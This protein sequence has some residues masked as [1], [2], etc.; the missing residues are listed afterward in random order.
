MTQEKIFAELDHLIGNDMMVLNFGLKDITEF[1]EANNIDLNMKVREPLPGE[2]PESIEDIG[3][4]LIR[5]A[6][7]IKD[8]LVEYREIKDT[9]QVT[10]A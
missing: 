9:W 4:V 2:D 7:S 8:F 3:A 10:T 5:M 1:L 6:L